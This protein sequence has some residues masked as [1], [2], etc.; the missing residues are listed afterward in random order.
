M[1]FSSTGVSLMNSVGMLLVSEMVLVVGEWFSPHDGWLLL[2][3]TLL[4]SMLLVSECCSHEWVVAPREHA[5]HERVLLLMSKWLLLVS[6]L[7][8]S[9]WCSS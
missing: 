7:L 2:M 8:M 9:K 1:V 6:T 3:S 5:P 4:M